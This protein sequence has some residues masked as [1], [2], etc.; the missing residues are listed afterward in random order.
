MDYKP[1]EAGI[2]RG[3]I[4]IYCDGQSFLNQIDVNATCVEYLK[5]IINE[6]GE[7]LHKLQFEH[8]QLLGVFVG[9]SLHYNYH[10]DLGYKIFYRKT[11][12]VNC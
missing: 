7:E 1:S 3:L 11:F 8:L 4:E 10:K 12:Q 6:N 5:F 9:Y 2:F